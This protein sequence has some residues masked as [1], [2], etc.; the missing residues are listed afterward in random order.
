MKR[1]NTTT[2]TLV[3]HNTKTMAGVTKIFLGHALPIFEIHWANAPPAPPCP[4]SVT[5]VVQIRSI[6]LDT[7]IL[8]LTFH[9]HSRTV[10]T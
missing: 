8:L 10:A 6:A 3:P 5:H 9:L 4:R 7:D 2:H 1:P